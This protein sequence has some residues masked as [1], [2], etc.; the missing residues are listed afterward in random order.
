MDSRFVHTVT[1]TDV[2]TQIIKSTV[3][4]YATQPLG[5]PQMVRITVVKIASVV[6]RIRVSFVFL[7]TGFVIVALVGQKGVKQNMREREREQIK[8]M[9]RLAGGVKVKMA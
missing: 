2:L 5:Y 3:T 1:F 4:F 7:S 6:I 9:Y 8:K